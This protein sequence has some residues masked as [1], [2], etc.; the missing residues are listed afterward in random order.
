MIDQRVE[1]IIHDSLLA[2][3]FAIVRV[4][5]SG[6]NYK[7]LQIMIER[8]DNKPVT[9]NDCE[10]VSK[11]ISTLFIV[12]DPIEEAYSLEVS[13]AGIDR[14]LIKKA[15]FERFVGQKVRVKTRE[16][17]NDTSKIKGILRGIKEDKIII[18]Q[19]GELVE[20]DFYNIQSANLD[21]E[22]DLFKK[23]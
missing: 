3:G 14:P 12:D 22:D 17:I 16:K 11:I 2:E 13:S 8:N 20:I 10:K 4:K 6:N 5:L 19:Q 18:E 1:Q 21:I 23:V 15:D 7:I 9:I